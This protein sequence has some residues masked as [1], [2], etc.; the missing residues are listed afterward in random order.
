[1]RPVRRAARRLA[2]AL[3]LAALLALCAVAAP[4]QQGRVPEVDAPGLHKAID[5][6]RGRVVVVN[7]WATWCGPCRRE[8]PEMERL[9]REIPEGELAMISVSVDFDRGTL[10]E[11]LERNPFGYPVLLAD[12]TLMDALD[13]DAIPRTWIFAPDGTLAR[14]HDGPASLQELR[15]AVRAAQGGPGRS[16]E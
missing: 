14:N 4:G 13:L 11:Y 10:E 1:M 7:F 8:L 9:R 6:A 3:G 2:R 12:A 5:A 15:G 16:K